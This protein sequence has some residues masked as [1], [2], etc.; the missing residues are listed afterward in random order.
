MW[1]SLETINNNGKIKNAVKIVG[2]YPQDFGV[3]RYCGISNNIVYYFASSSSSS[4]HLYMTLHQYDISHRK[5]TVILR[6][7]DM[8]DN[9]VTSLRSVRGKNIKN[10]AI[11]GMYIL[12]NDIYFEPYSLP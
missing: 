10:S 6:N 12:G 1:D 7:V 5:D 4:E 2:Y 8:G 9:Y 3:I 11:A